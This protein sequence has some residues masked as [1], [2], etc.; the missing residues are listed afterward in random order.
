M[1]G[2]AHPAWPCLAGA[3]LAAVLPGRSRRAVVVAAPAL[4]LL[5]A[6]A[7]PDGARLEGSLLGQPLVWLRADALARPFAI[8]FAL[9]A[10]LAGLYGADGSRRLHV[11]ALAGAAAGLGIVLAGD[12]ITL[13]AAWEAL[14]VASFVLV[15]DGG[16]RRAAGAALRYLLVHAAGGTALLAGIV[17]HRAAGGPALVGAL[18]AEGAALLL[19]A[20]FAVNAAIPPLHAWLTDAYPESSTA[21]SVFLSAFATKAAVYALLRVF[22]GTPA[23]LWAGAAMAIY[24]VVFAVLAN[25]VRRLLAYH[26]VSQVGYMVAGAGLGTPL[27]VAG[28]TAHAFCHILYK[29]LLFMAAGALERATGR[30]RLT[31]L[32]GLWRAL[33]STLALYMVGALSISG[34]PLLNGFVSKAL[35]VAAFD[36]EGRWLV[37]SALTLASVGTFL[38][39]ALKLPVLAFGGPPGPLAVAPV[40]RAATLAMVLAAALCVAIG[41]APRLLYR[42][43][44]GPVDYE[45]YTA[46]HVLVTLQLL[47][48]TAVGFLLA[49]PWLHGPAAVSVDF[50]RLYAALGRWVRRDLG[51]AAARGADL[52]EAGALAL[53]GRPVARM[54]GPV[55][56]PVGYA[57]LLIVVALGLSLTLFRGR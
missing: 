5:L 4:A 14:A 13:Y 17:A 20:G 9:L 56:R 15:T 24:G 54:R 42:L 49:E 7:L 55:S 8:V 48:G 44:P 36:A 10:G 45:P 1:T 39:V 51:G 2:W 3:A 16:T 41:V 18:P 57:V 43:L 35:V 30:R 25:D 38:S 40:P 22:P 52:L 12:W 6:S 53:A 34:A 23:L 27:A 21:G 19:L 32:G 50:D 26:I 28:A 37:A 31:D 33:P 29:G 11:A 47:A 46:D